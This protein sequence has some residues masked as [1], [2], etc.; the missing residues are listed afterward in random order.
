MLN[1]VDRTK[2]MFTK[3]RLQLPTKD[4][5]GYAYL[6]HIIHYTKSKYPWYTKAYVTDSYVSHDG[7]IKPTYE[8]L[9]R[10]IEGVC[11]RD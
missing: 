3:R 7:I 11:P 5:L 2:V 4:L 1:S 8:T 6:T 9:S 10:I